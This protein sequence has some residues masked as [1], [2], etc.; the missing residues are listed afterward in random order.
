MVTATHEER[1]SFTD[2]RNPEAGEMLEYRVGSRSTSVGEVSW[3]DP[4]RCT[5]PVTRTWPSA[6]R[7][8]LRQRPLAGRSPRRGRPAT[9][10]LRRSAIAVNADDTTDYCLSVPV[11]AGDA[12]S[13]ECTDRTVGQSYVVLVIA[14]DG[15]G[16]YMVGNVATQTVQ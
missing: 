16:G 10:P 8:T 7:A 15:Q 4:V 5:R 11:L 6:R 9:W 3:A 14:L 12:S 2:P 1:T 13:Y